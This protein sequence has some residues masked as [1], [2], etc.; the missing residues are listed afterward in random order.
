MLQD[1]NSLN[2]MRST[3]NAKYNIT[4]FRL[5]ISSDTLKRFDNKNVV[6]QKI[7]IQTIFVQHMSYI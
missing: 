1:N 7:N 5:K 4:D 6:F 2:E 3:I